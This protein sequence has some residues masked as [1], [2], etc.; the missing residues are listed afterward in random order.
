MK[1]VTFFAL[2]IGLLGLYSFS[3]PLQAD[4]DEDMPEKISAHLKSELYSVKSR[5]ESNRSSQVKKSY[6]Y[7]SGGS[8]LYMGKIEIRI[9]PF[10]TFQLPG[11]ASL[12][13]R[14]LFAFHWKKKPPTGW[15]KYSR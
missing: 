2:M 10:V 8:R 6:Y 5:L 12:R 3:L 7:E 13:I 15:E 1:K 9:R 14:P 4:D 11:I